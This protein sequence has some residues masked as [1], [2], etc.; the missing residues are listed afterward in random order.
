MVHFKNETEDRGRGC[1]DDVCSKGENRSARIMLD[2]HL[3]YLED[4][5]GALENMGVDRSMSAQENML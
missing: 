3:K 5:I 1:P 2:E 4:L